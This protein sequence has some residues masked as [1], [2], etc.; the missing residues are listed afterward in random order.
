MA[1]S[2]QIMGTSIL[3]KSSLISSTKL[4]KTFHNSNKRNCPVSSKNNFRGRR[5]LSVTPV[6]AISEDYYLIKKSQP[7][8]LGYNNKPDNDS[9]DA[10]IKVR[11][12]ITV[13]NK[14]KEDL[15]EALAKHFDN[16]SDKIGRNVVL[17][18][19]STDIDPSKHYFNSILFL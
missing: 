13:R 19:V 4:I 10:K 1:G 6:A 5:L 18:L 14:I 3:E 17:Q 16:F 12:V 2:K 9:G 11:A 7:S 15:K 8:D